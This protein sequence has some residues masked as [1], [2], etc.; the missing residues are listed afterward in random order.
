MAH[1]SEIYYNYIPACEQCGR[2]ASLVVTYP[3]TH[4]DGRV[5]NVTI[6]QD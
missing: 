1:A 5:V 3:V 2:K 6:P 4:K